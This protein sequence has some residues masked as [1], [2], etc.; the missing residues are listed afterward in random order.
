VQFLSTAAP[1]RGRERNPYLQLAVGSRLFELQ[2]GSSGDMMNEGK[3][4][5]IEPFHDLAV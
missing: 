4:P 1:K 5:L 3:A 2:G